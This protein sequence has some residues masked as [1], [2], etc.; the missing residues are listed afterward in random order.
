[1][2]WRWGSPLEKDMGSVEVLW[3]GD[4]VPPGVDRQISVKTVP[5]CHTTQ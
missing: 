5:S 2:G 4:G 1:M 3:D